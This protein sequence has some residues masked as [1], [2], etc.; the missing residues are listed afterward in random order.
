MTT[1]PETR[2]ARAQRRRGRAF[3]STFA[4]VVAV[5]AAVALSGAALSLVQG[6][7]L[8]GVQ[9]DPDA[10]VAA[11]GS[12]VIFTTTQALAEV[13]VEQVSV[14]PATE[15]TV[16]TS[17]RS[18][19]VRFALP[20]WD[21]TEYTIRI[22][23][24]TPVGGGAASTLEKTFTTPALEFQLLQRGEDEDTIFRTDLSGEARAVFRHPH[25]EDFRATRTHLV[26]STLD[27][28]GRSHLIVTDPDGGDE[29]ELT[30]PGEGVVSNLQ[31]ADRGDLVGYTFTDADIGAD[32]GRESALYTASLQAAE[33]EAPPTAVTLDGADPRVIDWRFVPGTDSILMLTFDGALT[34]VSGTEAVALGA[35]IGID[36]IARGSSQAIVERIDGPVVIDL[37]TAEEHP[38]AATA[39]ADGQPG[40]ITPLPGTSGATLRVLAQVD[41]FDLQATDVAVVTADGAATVVASVAPDD[42]L[43]HTC[44]SPS[45]RYAALLVA[46][47]AVDNP[48]DGYQLPLPRRLETRI[49]A[50][51]DAAPVVDLAGLGISW[52]QNGPPV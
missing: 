29:R 5:I 43:L 18:V 30:L 24:V 14:T 47:D 44:V 50:L 41:G 26:I 28:A 37:A 49:V 17:G 6:P 22:A 8:T 15:F 34:L 40:A 45:G 16:D 12:R 42:T 38:L 46:P 7:R 39:P 51:E 11:S 20:L 48:Y 35:A 36:G 27:E 13:G 25:I 31:S 10:A 19:G 2:R 1:T 3:A 33:L 4:V 32:G 52:C 23:E 21:D 9:V